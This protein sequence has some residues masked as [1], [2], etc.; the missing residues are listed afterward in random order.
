[1]LG[2]L[3]YTDF[4]CSQVLESLVGYDFLPRGVCLLR[5]ALRGFNARGVDPLLT[6]P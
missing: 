2:S 1:M 3:N 5:M 4:L 6:Q